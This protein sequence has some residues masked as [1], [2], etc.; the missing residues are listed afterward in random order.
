MKKRKNFLIVFSFFLVL[1]SVISFTGCETTRIGP[2][3]GTPTPPG[4]P[5]P[6]MLTIS[7]IDSKTGI[8]VTGASVELFKLDGTKL[9]IVPTISGATY[10]YNINDVGAATLKVTATA[11][12]YGTSFYKTKIDLVNK[13]T[14]LVILPIDKIV[15]TPGTLIPAGGS[16]TTSSTESKSPTPITITVPAGAVNTNTSITISAIPIN[17]VPLPAPATTLVVAAVS[18]QPAGI[19]F[20]KPVTITF[21]MPYLSSAGTQLQ[22][23]EFVNNVWVGTV[24]KATIDNTGLLA[25]VDVDKTAQYAL[26]DN[27]KL[28]G[29]FNISEIENE[30]ITL[31]PLTKEVEIFAGQIETL[32]TNEETSINRVVSSNATCTWISGLSNGQANFSF[33]WLNNVLNQAYGQRLNV[34]IPNFGSTTATFTQTLKIAWPTIPSGIKNQASGDGT[35]KVYVNVVELS[36]QTF[37]VTLDNPNMLKIQLTG[38]ATFYGLGSFNDNGQSYTFKWVFKEGHNQGQVIGFGN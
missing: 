20:A 15:S 18:V 21:P 16:V 30:N 32:T 8:G 37:D 5:T 4:P 23:M 7:V 24:L 22:L 36:P 12:G 17:N 33:E 31:K 6:L 38:Q 25:K 9:T 28:T 26:L 13:V 10:K 14:E 11:T 35:W 3:I 1:V 29:T 27:I 34:T 2:E 19:V